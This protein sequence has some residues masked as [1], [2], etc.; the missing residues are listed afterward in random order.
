MHLFKQADHMM[1]VI[2]VIAMRPQ[3]GSNYNP[4]R[5]CVKYNHTSFR[6]LPP[7]KNVTAG[8]ISCYLTD[9][10][11]SSDI[12]TAAQL[13]FQVA[14]QRITCGGGSAAIRILVAEISATVRG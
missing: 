10:R 12:C 9:N 4:N 11:S 13:K 7:P 3:I 6:I 1:P 14:I 8:E 5:M 2:A